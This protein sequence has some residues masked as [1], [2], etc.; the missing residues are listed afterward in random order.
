MGHTELQLE[1]AENLIAYGPARA[2]STPFPQSK[3]KHAQY[4]GKKSDED[5]TISNTSGA[6]A[7]STIHTKSSLGHCDPRATEAFQQANQAPSNRA[8]QQARGVKI[9]RAQ[10]PGWSSS[11]ARPRPLPPG[12]LLRASELLHDGAPTPELAG[13]LA[14]S[15]LHLATPIKKTN[16]ATS[17]HSTTTALPLLSPTIIHYT[18]DRRLFPSVPSAPANAFRAFL[19]ARITLL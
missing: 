3:P 8:F 5:Q 13:A 15:A 4:C 19:T 18:Q 2:T 11:L 17:A 10:T 14:A 1:L 12:P 7:Q 6:G 16:H 9:C